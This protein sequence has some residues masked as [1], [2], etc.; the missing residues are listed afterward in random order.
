MFA[1]RSPKLTTIARTAWLQA[2]KSDASLAR[3]FA[4]IILPLS[5]LPPLMLYYAGTY[6]GDAF[7]SGFSGRDW[8]SIA[9]V[10]FFAEL[11]TVAVM[12]PVIRGIAYLNGVSTDRGSA[13]LL[14]FAAPIPLWLSSLAL[15]VPNFFAAA[16][17]GVLALAFSCVIIYHGVSTLLR[18]RDDIVA[19]SIAYGIMACGMAAWAMLLII[20]IPVG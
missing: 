7:M 19:E 10:F 16:T 9:L 15:F 11:A 14:A 1:Y 5:L 20:V 8:R 4:K 3:I 6:H 12:G 13:G 2:D 18:V 17:V